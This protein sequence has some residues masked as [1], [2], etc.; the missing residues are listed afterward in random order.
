MKIETKLRSTVMS[1]GILAAVTGCA[2]PLT[3]TWTSDGAVEFACPIENA[4]FCDDGTFTAMAA[5]EEGV[6]RTRS[7]R[8]E[9]R[10]GKLKLDAGG[11]IREYDAK[12]DGDQLR[13][14]FD[15]HVHTMIRVK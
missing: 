8:F 14:I 10:S 3:G 2:S 11:A 4:S 5:F 9:Y 6:S 1:L 7:G 12:V 15:G 13:V